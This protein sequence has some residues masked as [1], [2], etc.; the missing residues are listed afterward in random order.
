MAYVSSLQALYYL[1]RI[2]M[3]V[4]SV[5]GLQNHPK[6]NSTARLIIMYPLVRQSI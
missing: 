5:S 1:P 4:E 2:M 3:P 6:H